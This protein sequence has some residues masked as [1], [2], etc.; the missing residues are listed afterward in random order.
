MDGA[1]CAACATPLVAGARYCT[2]CGRGV[3]SRA[4][5]LPWIVAGASVAALAAVLLLTWGPAA[6][7]PAEPGVAFR[8]APDRPQPLTGTPRE[9]ADRLFNRVMQAQ[10]AGDEA[11]LRFFLPMAVEAYRNAGELDPDGLYHLAV[12]QLA[13][14]AP[15]SALATAERILAREAD[16][17]LALGVALEA[18]E[19][20]GARAAGRRFAERLLARYEAGMA[21]PRPEYL[22]HE[23]ILP[24]YLEAARRAAGS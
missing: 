8:A 6:P 10:A 17:L 3:R 9:Q 18:A 1:V 11:E 21:A 4:A 14:G 7:P 12:L 23:R 22:H 19:A 13:G 5:S 20:V 24:R 16:H 2:R 15:D